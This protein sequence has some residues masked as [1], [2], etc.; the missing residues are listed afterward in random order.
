MIASD[1]SGSRR[2]TLLVATEAYSLLSATVGNLYCQ[3]VHRSISR[4]VNGRY[5][6]WK[7]LREFQ[8][9]W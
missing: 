5:R 8:L 1:C 2:W 6:C 7:C 4:P 9:R 3:L